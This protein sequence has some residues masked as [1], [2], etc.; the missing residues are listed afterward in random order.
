MTVRV[1][2]FA[3][4]RERLRAAEIEREVPAG[5]TV[6]ELVA[7]LHDE[8]PAFTGAGRVAIAVNAEYVGTAHR[9]ADG[10]EVALIP[11]VSGGCRRDGRSE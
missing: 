5:A 2:F 7:L 8:F 6:A 1:R 3:S 9:L 4:L 10:D 11:P